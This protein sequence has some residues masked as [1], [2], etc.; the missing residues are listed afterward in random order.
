[1][2]DAGGDDFDILYDCQRSSNP[3]WPSSSAPPSRRSDHSSSRNH[4]DPRPGQDEVARRKVKVPLCQGE[5]QF[6][7]LGLQEMINKHYISYIN[8]D[9]IHAGG[10]T[11]CK[12]LTQWPNPTS[13]TLHCT[14]PKPQ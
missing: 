10:I 3:R 13:S 8:P 12:K 4:A 1:M 5:S 9:V 14:T 2:R 7:K 11:E 6:T